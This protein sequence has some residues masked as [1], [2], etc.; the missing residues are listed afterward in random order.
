MTASDGVILR[1]L[2]HRLSNLLSTTFPYF[3]AFPSPVSLVDLVL[4][5]LGIKVGNELFENICLIAFLVCHQSILKLC[6]SYIE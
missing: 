3:G 5:I 4:L 1:L 6:C 2:G